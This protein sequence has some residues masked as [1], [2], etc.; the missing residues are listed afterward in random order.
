MSLS[1]FGHG[2]GHGLFISNLHSPRCEFVTLSDE[3]KLEIVQAC[4]A[5]QD[6]RSGQTDTSRPGQQRELRKCCIPSRVVESEW[7]RLKL[8]TRIESIQ[9]DHGHGHGHGHGILIIIVRYLKPAFDVKTSQSFGTVP[10][11]TPGRTR[12]WYIYLCPML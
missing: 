10:A 8:I 3:K 9:Y 6:S 1:G 12:S 7:P 11:F 2:H 5:V 4:T